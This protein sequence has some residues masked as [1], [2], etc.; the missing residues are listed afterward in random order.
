MRPRAGLPEELATCEVIEMG[1]GE[2]FEW[3]ES[4]PGWH[5]SREIAE[6]MGKPRTYVLHA[7]RSLIRHGEVV[8][9]G[10]GG[11]FPEYRAA[12]AVWCQLPMTEVMGL[13]LRD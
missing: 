5:P 3:L 7:L 1:Q 8:V 10:K 11:A 13:R 2:V 9:R 12:K 6:D 4:H